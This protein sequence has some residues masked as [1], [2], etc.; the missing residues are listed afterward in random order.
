MF[1]GHDTADAHENYTTKPI[2]ITNSANMQPYIPLV[3]IGVLTTPN[4]V[5]IMLSP[6]GA[7]P[8]HN[9]ILNGNFS[10]VQCQNGTLLIPT[11]QDVSDPNAVNAVHENGAAQYHNTA[12]GSTVNE[13]SMALSSIAQHNDKPFQCSQCD[14]SFSKLSYLR[15]HEKRHKTLLKVRTR[16]VAKKQTSK[17]AARKQQMPAKMKKSAPPTN[18]PKGALQIAPLSVPQ[19]ALHSAPTSALPPGALQIAPLSA[20]ANAL[21]SALI[22]APR[23]APPVENNMSSDSTKQTRVLQQCRVPPEVLSALCVIG[24]SSTRRFSLNTC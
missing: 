1:P 7:D 5:N 22:S 13:N 14:R 17:S 19:N 18:A 12:D 2:H 24:C 23:S 6:Q 9:S 20:P 4:Q 10:V 11:K 15:K 21:H 3:D 16:V 8:I